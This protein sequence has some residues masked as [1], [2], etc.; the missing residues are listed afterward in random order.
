MPLGLHEALGM[1]KSTQLSFGRAKVKH[2]FG[3]IKLR[4]G[5]A[6]VRYRG[7]AKNAS[8]FYS[9]AA[10]TNVLRAQ[11]YERRHGIGAPGI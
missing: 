6:K 11:S 7:L 4:F 3:M 2:V 5:Y 9:L 1:E 10:L 8:R